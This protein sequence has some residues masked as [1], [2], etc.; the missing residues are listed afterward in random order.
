[1]KFPGVGPK[2]AQGEDRQTALSLL[3]IVNGNDL[4]AK[5]AAQVWFVVLNMIQGRKVN[6]LVSRS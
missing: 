2:A 4:L 3:P 6:L 5:S 1:M